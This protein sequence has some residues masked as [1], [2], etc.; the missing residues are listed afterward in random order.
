VDSNFD[1]NSINL[2]ETPTNFKQTTLEE[3]RNRALT[4]ELE[5][6]DLLKEQQRLQYLIEELTNE[7]A[8]Q[9]NN[10]QR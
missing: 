7:L 2:I 6:R 5:V 8:V 10:K 3:W 9:A 1:S 4:A